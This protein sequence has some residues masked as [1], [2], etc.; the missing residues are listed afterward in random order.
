MPW[1]SVPLSEVLLISRFGSLAPTFASGAFMPTRTFG[2][3]HTT[4]TFEAPLFTRQTV[5]LSAFGCFSTEST[6]PTTTPANCGPT[7]A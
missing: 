4:C 5:S 1:L 7:G 6:S 3:P 2:A